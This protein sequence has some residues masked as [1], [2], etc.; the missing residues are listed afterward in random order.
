MSTHDIEGR[1]RPTR[2]DRTIIPA[3]RKQGRA[4]EQHP[5]RRCHCGTPLSRYNPGPTCYLHAPLKF[6]RVRGVDQAGR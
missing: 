5:P 4:P 2:R 3:P 1:A 6:P